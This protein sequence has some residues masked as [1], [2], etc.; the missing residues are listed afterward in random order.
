MTKLIQYIY[1]F[2]EN[3]GRA[4]AAAECIRIGRPDLA[5]N[6]MMIND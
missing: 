5:R 4:R 3:M 6:L 1:E 2:L